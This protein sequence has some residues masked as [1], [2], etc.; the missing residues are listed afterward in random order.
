MIL[1]FVEP[2]A[3]VPP[4]VPI[5]G[6]FGCSNWFYDSTVQNPYEPPS[7]CYPAYSWTYLI[8]P[9]SVAL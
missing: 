3:Y 2:S 6:K 1:L 5:F 4:D 8:L 9:S 7:W